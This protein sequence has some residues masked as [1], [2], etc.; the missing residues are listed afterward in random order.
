[1]KKTLTLISTLFLATAAGAQTLNVTTGSVTYQFPATQTGDMTYADGTTLIILDKTFTLSEVTGMTVDDTEVADDAINVAYNGTTACV[2]VAGNIAR[3]VK[4][5]VSGAHVNITQSDDL[6]SEITYTLSGSSSDG[7]FYMEGNHNATLVMNG[8][9][10]TNATPISSGA[11]IHI[12]N[13]KR[14]NI[15]LAEGTTNTLV[16]AASGSQEGCLYVKGHAEFK[17]QGTLNVTGQVKHGI[18]TGCYISVNNATINVLSAVGDGIN[19]NQYFLME[20]GTVSISDTGDDGIRCDI[21]G[22]ESTGETTGHVDEDSGNIYICGGVIKA[23][24]TATAA[25]GMKCE[26][27]ISVT[28]GTINVTTTGHEAG[29]IESENE[30]TICGG[31]ITVDSYG[32]GI[33]AARNIIIKGGSVIV[34]ASGNDAIVSGGD[35]QISGGYMVACG[36][37]YGLNT[38]EGCNLY[39]TGGT[40]CAIGGSNKHVTII[41]ES[42]SVLN[43]SATVSAGSVISVKLDS[44][45]L[46][47]FT[48]PSF[49]FPNP[50]W[51]AD[52]HV[53]DI[54]ERNG[55]NVLI[56][57][58]GILYGMRH[59]VIVDS[60]SH[61]VIAL[62]VPF[63]SMT[64]FEQTIINQSLITSSS[65][66]Y[67]DCDK[68]GIAIPKLAVINFT[69]EEGNLVLPT[70]KGVDLH[71]IV[72]FSSEGTYF[73]KAVLL[74]AQG[75]SSMG[76]KKKNIAVALLNN[77]VW[78]NGDDGFKEFSLRFGEW[79]SQ[80]K[81]HLKA[82]YN[83]FFKGV[84]PAVGYRLYMEIQETLGQD[85]NRTYKRALY[86]GNSD[87]YA[88]MDMK[89]SGLNIDNESRENVEEDVR[90]VPDGFPC[91]VFLNGKFYGIYSWQLKKHR[92]NYMM[93]K[94][95]T[96]HIHLDGAL[97]QTHIWSGEMNWNGIEVRN[98]KKLVNSEGGDYEENDELMGEDNAGY[99][100]NDKNHVNSNMVKKSILQL[101]SYVSE[102]KNMEKEN[103]SEIEIRGRMEQMFDIQSLIDYIVICNY[104]GNA[105]AFEKNWQ[106]T[107]WDGVRWAANPYDMDCLFGNGP[108]GTQH[109][110]RDWILG[111]GNNLPTR[112][113]H[114][115]YAQEIRKRYA[116]LRSAGLLSPDHVCQMLQQWMDR[117]G[118]E[119][120]KREYE[121]ENAAWPNSPCCRPSLLNEEYWEVFTSSSLPYR[122][123]AFLYD[124]NK[125]YI[126]SSTA[127]QGNV[128]L[129][130][131]GSSPTAKNSGS[132]YM[133]FRCIKQCTGIPPVSGIYT[134][135]AE[136]PLKTSGKPVI[137][138]TFDSVERVNKWLV[139]QQQMLDEKWDYGE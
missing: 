139:K 81:F 75:N 29:G 60:I 104:L 118:D 106:W 111:R 79:V 62:K 72:E 124:P 78:D 82:F 87:E 91:L 133:G 131:Y 32:D 77:M 3:Y 5:N 25:K 19:C 65:L 2:N 36:D 86:N 138:G 135:T 88:E 105:D 28:D 22:T 129:Y 9:T 17:Q 110:F 69:N 90:C 50:R 26:G 100:P 84:C 76:Y 126:P 119:W 24:C 137:L 23:T 136:W 128:C 117:I 66:D 56:S 10:L 120:Y 54:P 15:K 57:Y 13:G 74:N 83:D 127:S 89:E 130:G 122:T 31:S 1:M 49:Y 116:D 61:E 48:V 63:D 114:D 21:D 53:L 123:D 7:E 109:S 44:V 93:D 98:P 97:S 42:Q 30:M 107:T 71:G 39:I 27:D 113:V 12:Q 18:K 43:T 37:K 115:H 95:E 35:L 34:A 55:V 46:A 102:I 112:L 51:E 99:D 4:V 41:R 64:E 8:L 67:T 38:A 20:S 73:K 101:S 68:A 85:N 40:V 52:D 6:A 16:D 33:N 125:T 59:K 70:A 92:D 11:A 121:G 58:E 103:A 132:Y 80:E 14:I 94:R 47:S 45:A 108:T 134:S 96:K